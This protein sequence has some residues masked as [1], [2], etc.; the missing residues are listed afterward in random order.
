MKIYP[1]QVALLTA[2]PSVQGVAAT[3]EKS[4]NIL[5][6]NID[7]LGW[8]DLSGNGS[9]YYETPHIDSLKNAG[10][11]F[12]QAYAGAS[13]SA[14]SRACMLTGQYAP[15]HGIFTVHPAD[16]GK[17]ADRKLIS[18]PNRKSLPDGFQILPRVLKAAGYQTFHV[19]KWHVT[20]NPSECGIDINVGGHHAGHPKRYFSPYGN[21]Y[22]SD[23]PEG[24]FLTDRL[25][26]EAASLIMNA[27]RS[28]PFFLYY[29]PY[30]VHTP[31][32][33]KAELIEKYRRKSPTKAHSN[34]VYAALIETMDQNVGRVLAALKASGQLENTL[35]IFTTDNGGVYDISRQW[36]LRA[37]KGSFYEGGIRIPLIIARH[38]M[39]K[40]GEQHDCYV[41][42]VDLFPTILDMA[43]IKEEGLLLDGRSLKKLLVK[44]KDKAL[45]DRPLFWHF[46]AYLE[47]G[48]AESTDP[49]FRSRPVSVIRK[50]D[51]KLI[52]NYESGTYELYNLRDDL[53]EKT[54]LAEHNPKKVKELVK[55]LESWKKD[56]K[57]P[58]PTQL[59][60]AYKG[61]AQ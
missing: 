14:P 44:G 54:D 8:A 20:G 43:G 41:S 21:P 53:S 36:P 23:G 28:K 42:Q 46:P 59:N 4:P 29:A 33:A 18:C 38:G 61:N 39:L 49:I 1:I 57:A 50:G 24:E 32:Q 30:A 35:V 22:L 11:W 6:I 10:I 27:D 2:L 17:A 31:L 15:R 55:E 16:R 26:R 25:G 3:Q 37:G 56:V 51:W 9:D 48:N 12:S 60:P 34:L 45:E 47:G 19:G 40:A 7:D 13:N 52:E 58:I 5:L